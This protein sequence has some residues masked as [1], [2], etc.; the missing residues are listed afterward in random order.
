M[1]KI[2]FF[3]LAPFYLTAAFIM[4]FSFEWWTELLDE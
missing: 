4:H 3:L 2:L 1:K